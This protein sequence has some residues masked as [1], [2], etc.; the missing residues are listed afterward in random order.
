MQ[1]L[2]N[3]VAQK[4]CTDRGDHLDDICHDKISTCMWLRVCPN[5]YEHMYE[6]IYTYTYTYKHIYIYIHVH[7]L[8]IMV[9]GYLRLD[10]T[11]NQNLQTVPEVTS[12]TSKIEAYCH[13]W[14][15][16]TNMFL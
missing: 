10:T 2:S 14:C 3:E 6:N 8:Y 13:T 1:W 11:Q 9:N 12:Q 5:M 15:L 7:K 4:T 16:S